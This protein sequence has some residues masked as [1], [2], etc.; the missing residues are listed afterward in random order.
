MLH[1]DRF[2]TVIAGFLLFISV[3]L[4]IMDMFTWTNTF[5]IYLP[6]VTASFVLILIKKYRSRKGAPKAKKQVA[7]KPVARARKTTLSRAKKAKPAKKKVTK[8]RT[9]RKKK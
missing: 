5:A 6:L 9:T 4:L 3:W 1:K 8:R 7:R 2:L